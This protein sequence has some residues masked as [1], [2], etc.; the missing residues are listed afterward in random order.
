MPLSTLRRVGEFN[1]SFRFHLDAEWLGRLADAKLK[2]L[3]M[4][5][6]T[7]P[8]EL[9]H[10][11]DVRPTL[12]YLINFSVGQCRLA[13]HQSPYPLVKRLVHS[14]SGMAQ[15]ETNKSLKDISEKEN[16]LLF[17]RFGRPPW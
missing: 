5:E 17:K 11:N 10:I 3:H 15:I 6:S 9:K 12:A 14:K 7:A 2:R 16:E 4:V 1:E 8:I 13:R